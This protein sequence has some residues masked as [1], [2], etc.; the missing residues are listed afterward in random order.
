MYHIGKQI[1]K[2]A[3]AIVNE[4]VHK[5]SGECVAIK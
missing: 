1:G 5:P 4:S 3:Y 2:G